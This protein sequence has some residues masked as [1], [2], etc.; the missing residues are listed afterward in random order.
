[1]NKRCIFF[2]FDGVL[3]DAS[4]GLFQAWSEAFSE[5]GVQITREEYFSREGMSSKA[6]AEKILIENGKDI[7][8][9]EEIAY[10]KDAKYCNGGN[11]PIYP[12]VRD[13]LGFVGAVGYKTAIV[14]GGSR[15]RIGMFLE[16]NRWLKVDAIIT[17]DD[18]QRCKPHPEPYLKAAEVVGALPSECVVVENAP[19]GIE[20]A[21]RAGMYCIAVTT[22]LSPDYLE[23]SDLIVNDLGEVID[24]LR[25]FSQE[26]RY[27]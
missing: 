3:A 12:H 6:L 11:F 19:L 5:I 13:L 27:E 20:S 17:A 1:M 21:K 25:G 18:C 22:T 15:R 24:V 16:N 23:G 26:C 14:S 9:A 8:L 7:G 2:D 4:D 10:K